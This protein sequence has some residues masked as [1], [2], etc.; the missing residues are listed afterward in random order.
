MLSEK[1]SVR[2]DVDAFLAAL[3]SQATPPLNEIPIDIAREALSRRIETADVEPRPLAVI[4]DLTC[5]APDGTTVPVRLY[6]PRGRRG[7]GPMMVYFH[8]GGFVFGSVDTHHSLC[9]ELAAVLDIPVVS[10]E[11]RLAPEHR[12]PAA[13]NDCEAVARWVA[14][15]RS[16]IGRD[17]TSLVLAGDSAGGTLAAVTAI[18]LRN[19]PAAVPVIAQWVLYPATD[20]ENYRNYGSYA[21][22]RDGYTITDDGVDWYDECYQPNVTHWRASP[23]K[24]DL[25]GLPAAL[26]VTAE[27]D[28]LRDQGRAYANALIE[29]GVAT[30]YREAAG[31][32]HGFANYRHAIPSS[33]ID[34]AQS[35]DLLRVM[36]DQAANP[37]PG[38][39]REAG[40]AT[41][42]G[43]R[44]ISG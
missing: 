36:L 13:P 7:P 33:V 37:L 14:D 43:K 11:Y 25:T 6:D 8:G 1:H 28:P 41:Q 4:R 35:V 34:V 18:A 22:F 42:D 5:A 3:N 26:V 38:D 12:W 15:P 39:T 32:I 29:A 2:P 40:I 16:E 30:I 44:C 9:A 17:V 27:L 24:A 20:M 23:L 31:T 19:D 21:A 10:V